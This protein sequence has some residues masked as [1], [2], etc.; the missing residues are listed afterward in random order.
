MNFIEFQPCHDSYESWL[1]HMVQWTSLISS[2]IN[3]AHAPKLLLLL[4]RTPFGEFVIQAVVAMMDQSGNEQ[5]KTS[6]QS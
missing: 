3:A 6:F 5:T 1:F 4:L 2:A